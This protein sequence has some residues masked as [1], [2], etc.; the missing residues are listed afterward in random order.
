MIWTLQDADSEYH[1]AKGQL[2]LWRVYK[3]EVKYRLEVISRNANEA[4][5][6]RDAMLGKDIAELMEREGRLW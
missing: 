1:T 4:Y 3:D 6:V 5:I 2:G